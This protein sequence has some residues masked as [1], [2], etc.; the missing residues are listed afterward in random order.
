MGSHA[1]KVL[2]HAA[3]TTSSAT[4]TTLI[5]CPSG[6]VYTIYFAALY[7]A[8]GSTANRIKGY[9]ELSDTAGTNFHRVSNIFE[10]DNA[11]GASTFQAA[12]MG[13]V[14]DPTAVTEPPSAGTISMYGLSMEYGQVLRFNCSDAG[15]GGAPA[16]SGSAVVC[17][18]DSTL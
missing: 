10:T 2:A 11:G 16:P 1:L 7:L 12:G 9:F 6:H 18:I 14:N 5:T 15:A 8:E 17:G 3:V 4:N 13:A